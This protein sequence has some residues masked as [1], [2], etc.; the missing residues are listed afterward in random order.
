[1]YN[2]GIVGTVGCDCDKNGVAVAAEVVVGWEGSGMFERK[3]CDA[4]PEVKAVVVVAGVEACCDCPKLNND[5]AAGVVAVVV[6][7]F[8]AEEDVSG[9]SVVTDD[10]EKLKFEA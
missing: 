7:A 9:K 6:G 1:M 2:L 3:L 10:V 4:T 5:A 8:V